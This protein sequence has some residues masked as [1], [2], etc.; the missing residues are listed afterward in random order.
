MAAA[1]QA[2]SADL[3][4]L[5]DEVGGNVEVSVSG[6]FDVTG[7]TVFFNGS[8]TSADSEVGLDTSGTRAAA[9]GTPTVAIDFIAWTN[10]GGNAAVTGLSSFTGSLV[11]GA[12]AAPTTGSSVLLVSDNRI[13]YT[14]DPSFPNE[15][16]DPS[17]MET[18]VYAT[19]DLLTLIGDDDFTVVYSFPD[20]DGAGPGIAQSVT[21]TTVPEPSGVLFGILSMLTLV[22]FRRRAR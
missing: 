5:F 19:T 12:A 21:F 18:L 6:G 4:V 8:L 11:T 13:F 7:W 17:R 15:P 16:Y 22:T 3:V 9:A 20:P 2:A 14:G 1:T 10:P